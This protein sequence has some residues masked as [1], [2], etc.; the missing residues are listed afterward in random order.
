MLDQSALLWIVSVILTIAGLSGLLPPVV[1]GAPFL[2]LGLL[3]GAWAEGF[4]Y[5]G[6]G[7]LLILVAMAAM[8]YVVSALA[9]VAMLVQ[10][11]MIFLARSQ[12]N[13]E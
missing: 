6:I 3:F 2:F 11:I 5:I 13:D 7:T 10:Y 9:S 8:T 4:T 1:P 12:G